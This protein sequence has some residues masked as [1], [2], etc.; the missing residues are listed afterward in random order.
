[1]R[2]R[3]MFWLVATA[4]NLTAAD[5]VKLLPTPLEL[6]DRIGPLA[7]DGK[8]HDYGDPRLGKSYGY[9]ADGLT[10]T[11][12]VY[13]KGIAGL[14]DGGDSMA[15]CQE[16]EAAKDDIGRTSAYQNVKLQV[17]QLARLA[18]PEP[19]PLA[20]EARF[21][22]DM[23]STPSVSYV[24]ITA[25]SKHFVKLR[26]SAHADWRDE[27]PDARLAILSALGAALAPHAA[28][29]APT[30][31]QADA[32]ETDQ[33]HEAITITINSGVE[34]DDSSLGLAYLMALAAF[35]DEAPDGA[36]PCGG[37]V[38]PTFALEQEAYRS[39][40]RV[41]SESK[42]SSSLARTLLGIDSAGFLDEFV[43]TYLH[44]DSWG[45]AVPAGLELDAF[46]RY[47][48]KRLKRFEAPYFGRLEVKSPRPIAM[49][50]VE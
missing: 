28:P 29:A 23:H 24:W 46:A 47:R 38:I 11:V 8:P 39:L 34:G 37:E 45:D 15:V 13:D 6:P 26:F 27:L 7:Y 40:L 42:A 35:N 43:W 48:K 12:Y 10:L 21:E 17:E 14:P 44:R 4:A 22:L 5:P 1:M 20:R 31:T 3:T 32:L 2:T 18:F 25:A 19:W 9:R 41:A 33:G 50:P 16:F 30:G 49:E 36:P